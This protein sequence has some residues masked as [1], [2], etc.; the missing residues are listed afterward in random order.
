ME[1]WILCLLWVLF[2]SSHSF[3]AALNIKRKIQAFMGKWYIWYRLLYSV[4]SA[5]LFLTIFIYSGTIEPNWIFAQSDGT[6]YMGFMLATF[7]TIISVKSMKNQRLIHFLGLKPYNDLQNH[8]KLITSGIF[9][10]L[11]HPL[12]SGLI[13]I[14]IGYFLYVPA[15]TSMVHLMALLVYLPIGIYFEEN[16]LIALFGDGY[17]SYRS[18]VP[19]LIPKINSLWKS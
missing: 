15:L 17:R 4:F 3:F 8:D 1:Y 2:Y 9:Q 14:F 7:G 10:Y 6:S 5:I 11:R 12:Y 18:N 13:L 19:A 16:K